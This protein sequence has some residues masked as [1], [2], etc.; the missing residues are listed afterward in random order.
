MIDERL[1]HLI[2]RV[3]KK[4][5][6]YYLYD[7][8]TLDN[9]IATLTGAFHKEQILYSMK[10]NPNRAILKRIFSSGIDADAASL[11]EVY[12]A[13]DCGVPP[14]HIYYSAPGKTD[15]DI[16]NALGQ[17][18]LIA[19]SLNE[20]RRIN[21]LACHK[22]MKALIGIRI[23]PS[24]SLT[25]SIGDPS[26][27]GVDEEQFLAFLPELK[28]LSHVVLIGI[29]TH[30]QSQLLDEHLLSTYYKKVFSMAA[31]IQ[32][33]MGS[34]LLFL[35][36][37]SGIGIPYCRDES[38]MDVFSLA[39]Q[40]EHLRFVR[41]DSFAQARI[42]IESGRYLAGPCGWYITHVIDTKESRGKHIAIV[43]STLNGFARPSLE[44]LVTSIDP[45]AP[46]REPLFYRAQST[47]FFVLNE[48]DEKEKATLYGNLCTAAD[49]IASD[50]LLPKLSVGDALAFP[51]A[52]AY[53]AVMTPMQFSFQI[54]PGEI[55]VSRDGTLHV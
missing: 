5:A 11:G 9:S 20:L 1:R 44:H 36:L 2:A 52:G 39:K 45:S 14:D 31:H 29:H 42:L 38:N 40:L 26:K 19:D 16:A 12:A 22:N 4:Y 3:P 51:N 23:N 54:K 24:F 32:H 6:S 13:N 47:P 41:E 28:T 46:S 43:A 55:Y 15:F 50:V 33:T 37:G 49:I 34:P 17:C 30:M 8:V 21:N 35:N 18:I 48:T 27:F 7:E 25:G 10:C 53:S